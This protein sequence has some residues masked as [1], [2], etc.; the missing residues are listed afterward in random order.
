M[1]PDPDRLIQPYL[2]LLKPST[3]FLCQILATREADLIVLL[4]A[5][6]K[7]WE[8]KHE[9][10]TEYGVDPASVQ[11]AMRNRLEK[12]A[13]FLGGCWVLT[14]LEHDAIKAIGAMT[15]TEFFG[16]GDILIR[17]GVVGECMYFLESGTC[18]VSDVDPGTWQS[19]AGQDW[20]R[21]ELYP[22]IMTD[23]GHGDQRRG[24]FAVDQDNKR[25]ESNAGS[26]LEENLAALAGDENDTTKMTPA[27]LAIHKHRIAAMD[28][29][30]K[31]HRV[32]E[33]IC[34]DMLE[35]RVTRVYEAGDHFGELALMS[36]Y[37]DQRH[38]FITC[39]TA[40]KVQ[41]VDRGSFREFPRTALR[42]MADSCSLYFISDVLAADCLDQAELWDIAQSL[43]MVIAE[44]GEVILKEG[45]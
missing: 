36:D 14:G 28:R 44:D 1:R 35:G 19:I 40:V 18:V 3:L 12:K 8:K 9:E 37:S 29:F 21:S 41:S 26:T 38:C 32:G 4:A 10:E 31:E 39:V 24:S 42:K 22:S 7:E 34:D 5:K 20:R 45:P 30:Q 17:K 27:Q 25:R 23:I 13:E 33:G 16:A 43:E 11:L 15:N 6:R 2:D